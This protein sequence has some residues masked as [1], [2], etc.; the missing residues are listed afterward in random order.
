MQ[1]NSIAE[2]IA[3]SLSYLTTEELNSI[4][5]ISFNIIYKREKETTDQL[6]KFAGVAA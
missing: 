4:R 6:K 5:E 1:K 2:T 3:S